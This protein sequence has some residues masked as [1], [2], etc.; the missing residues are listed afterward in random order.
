MKKM[1]KPIPM[2]GIATDERLNFPTAAM[3][4]AVMVVPKF[5]PMITAIDSDR[6]NKPA[7]TKDTTITVVAEED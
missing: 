1:G 6:V 3:I 2:M 4:Q 7:L 5:A